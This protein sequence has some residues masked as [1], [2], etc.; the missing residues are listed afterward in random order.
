MLI[1]QKQKPWFLQKITLHA[2]LISILRKALQTLSPDTV[3]DFHEGTCNFHIFTFTSSHCESLD[4][5]APSLSQMH[6]IT[7]LSGGFISRDGKKKPGLK[8]LCL[9]SIFKL[10]YFFFEGYSWHSNV[11]MSDIIWEQRENVRY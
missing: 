7:A 9:F 4:S 10:S 8:I 6:P 11:H 1:V 5:S 3:C 2:A